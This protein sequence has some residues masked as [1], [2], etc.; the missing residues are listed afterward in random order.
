MTG[1]VARVLTTT[2][3]AT[4]SS[5]NACDANRLP[6]VPSL[7][8]LFFR[9]LNQEIEQI[10]KRGHSHT[11]RLCVC[12]YVNGKITFHT[13]QARRQRCSPLF[14]KP[15]FVGASF[16]PFSLPVTDCVCVLCLGDAPEV[17]L[18][19]S[20]VSKSQKKK[21][22]LLLLPCRVFKE[23][24]EGHLFHPLEGKTTWPSIFSS[25]FYF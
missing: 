8:L 10:N 24:L 4:V 17:S 12:I 18:L 5:R 9:V 1:A 25:F 23:V 2:G 15:M 7:L 6:S 16:P 19:P 13:F 14:S 3:N 20:G 21:K 22:T 11:H